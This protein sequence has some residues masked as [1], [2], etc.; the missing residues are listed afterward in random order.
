VGDLVFPFLWLEHGGLRAENLQDSVSQ[1]AG[2]NNQTYDTVHREKGRI[3]PAQ[4]SGPHKS[5]LP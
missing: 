1:G 2:K 3:Q 4:I 5:M